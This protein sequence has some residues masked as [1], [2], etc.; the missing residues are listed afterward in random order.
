MKR[1]VKVDNFPC[2][3]VRAQPSLT[4]YVL[5]GLAPGAEVDVLDIRGDWAA[6][7]L[8][9]GGA[10]IGDTGDMKQPATAF[11]FAGYLAGETLPPPTLKQIRARR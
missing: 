6:I 3:R 10:P 2:L 5:G 1:R 4:A 11:V 7:A 8:Q 9:A